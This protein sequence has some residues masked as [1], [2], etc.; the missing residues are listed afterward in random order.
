VYNEVQKEYADRQERYEEE[1]EHGLIPGAQQ[2][3]QNMI[4]AELNTMDRWRDD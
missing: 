3:W 1:T 4:A 2:R